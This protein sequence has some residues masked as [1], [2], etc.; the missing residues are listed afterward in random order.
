MKIY[1]F[2]SGLSATMNSGAEG[3]ENVCWA[4]KCHF[5]GGGQKWLGKI[6][7]EREGT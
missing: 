1:N 3:M 6:F 7:T 2:R 5:L 4:P